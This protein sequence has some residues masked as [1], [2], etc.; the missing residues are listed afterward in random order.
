LQVDLPVDLLKILQ[1][2]VAASGLT[3][4]EW[5]RTA[6]RESAEAQAEKRSSGK[7][8]AIHDRV[9]HVAR[10]L[11]KMSDR[12]GELYA[13]AKA[14]EAD[15]RARDGSRTAEILD[16]FGRIG[17]GLTTLNARIEAL[18]SV[19]QTQRLLVSAL[20]LG[21]TVS[22]RNELIA[23]LAD[24]QNLKQRMNDWLRG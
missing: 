23:I 11:G 6:M 18:E 19:V 8:D 22:V 14:I 5:I 21:S 17:E 13:Q 10:S 20:V 24:P 7:L 2:S 12:V 15:Q 16:A 9:D 3:Q 4:A 1:Q